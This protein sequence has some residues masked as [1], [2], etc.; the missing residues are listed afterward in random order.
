MRYL[1]ILLLLFMLTACKNSKKQGTYDIVTGNWFVLYPQSGD[2][3]DQKQEDLYNKMQDS[4][5]TLKGLKLITFHGNGDFEQLDS[6]PL[7]GRW[8]TKDKNVVFVNGAGKGFDNFKS[9]FLRYE[10]GNMLLS[11]IL[12][13]EGEKIAVTWHLKKIESGRVTELFDKDK[14]AWRKVPDHD[15]TD[16][17]MRERLSLMLRYYA[18]YFKLIADESS[19]FMPSRVMLPFSF[20]QHAIGMKT[21]DEKIKFVRLFHSTAQARIAYAMLDGAIER[22]KF[23]IPAKESYSEEYSLMLDMLAD[24]LKK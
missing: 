8:G 23:D 18:V 15:E 14:N 11:E 16:M 17:E 1:P 22:V 3:A 10:D 6:F 9:T 13:S 20:Y 24:E 19:Y 2:D 4:I 21:F 12:N 5:V 7:K